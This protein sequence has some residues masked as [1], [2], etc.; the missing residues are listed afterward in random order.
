MAIRAKLGQ[1]FLADTRYSDRIVALL[2][3]GLAS[4]LEVGPGQGA[5]SAL[6]IARYP[7]ATYY[8]VE[9]DTSLCRLLQEKFGERLRLIPAD[10]RS[11]Q[12]AE[13]LPGGSVGLVGNMPYFIS[14][15][16]VN[17]IIAQY[18]MIGSAVLM[19]QKDFVAKL[20]SGPGS[21]RYNAQGVMLNHLFALTVAFHVPAGAFQ[22]APKVNS[23]VVVAKKNEI[24]AG[25]SNPA[26]YEFLKLCFGHR[27][28]TFLNNLKRKF[29]EEKIRATFQSLDLA[30]TLRAEEA[31]SQLFPLLFQHLSQF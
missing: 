19:F 11:V 10:I 26:F 16:I 25:F 6:I 21:R 31:P 22:P 29:N 23:T 8:A 17:W 30:S 15:E 27:R 9:I 3:P 2:D 12:L 7:D 20:V 28:Q 1:H 24:P 13:L 4:I 14:K 18:P 5:L